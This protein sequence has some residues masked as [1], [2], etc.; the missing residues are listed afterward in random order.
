MHYVKVTLL[1]PNFDDSAVEEEERSRV[2]YH[3]QDYN[4][5]YSNEPRSFFADIR[6][7]PGLL[8]RSFRQMF[9]I[10]GI[11]IIER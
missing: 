3:I 6:D 4:E 9:S 7:L 1:R 2:L 5:L 11:V 8:L 10:S